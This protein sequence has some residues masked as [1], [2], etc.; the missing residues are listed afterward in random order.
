MA[1][2][3]PNTIEVE[4]VIEYAQT[5]VRALLQQRAEITK[6][7]TAIRRTIVD[8][9]KIFGH[10]GLSQERLTLIKPPKRNRRTGLTEACLS[11]LVESSQPLTAQE[12]VER[13]RASNELMNHHKD[14]IASVTAILVRLESYGEAA[15]DVGSSRRRLWMSKNSGDVK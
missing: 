11:V 6:R 2:A 8:L 5:E 14:P 12:V 1:T 15:S 3:I 7:I 13:M 4:P 10:D 9:A